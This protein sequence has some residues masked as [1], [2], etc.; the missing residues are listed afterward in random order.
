MQLYLV[1]SDFTLFSDFTYFLDFPE[2]GDLFEQRDERWVGGAEWRGSWARRWKGRQVENRVGL[3]VRADHID[4]GLFRN[5]QNLERFSTVRED[6][7]ELIGGA[8]WIESSVRWNEWFR[9]VAGLRL[10][11]WATSVDSD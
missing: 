11:L 7:I 8:P 4:N 5:R 9:T 3:E 2:E 10:D 6:D 1:A